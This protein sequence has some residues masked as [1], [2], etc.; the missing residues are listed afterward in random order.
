MKSIAVYCGAAHGANPVYTEAAR[1]LGRVLVEQGITL[2]YGGGAVGLMGE[3]ANEVLRCGGRAIGVIP[4]AL[5]D[6]EVGHKGLTEL[7][8]VPDMHVRKAMMADLAE[9]FIAM[10][11][12]IGTLEELFEMVTWCQLGIHRKPVGLL[13]VNGFW[14]GLL[15]YLLH[16]QHE[17]FLRSDA[18]ALMMCETTPEAIVAR[19]QGVLAHTPART[20]H[21][22]LR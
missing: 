3:I 21:P 9:G 7:H 6:K 13:N 20:D 4:Q 11:G 16:M 14:D 17:G 1:A 15:S 2:V 8:V 22:E 18:S 5:M 12:G 19:L 10:P